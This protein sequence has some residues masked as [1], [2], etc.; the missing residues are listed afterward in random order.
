MKALLLIAHGSRRQASND[1]VVSLADAIAGEMND[2]YPIVQAGF[3]EIV[4]PS[5]TEA[6]DRCV[7][8]GACVRRCARGCGPGP[9]DPWRYYNYNYSPYWRIP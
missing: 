3:L 7:Q 5:I 6:I 9:A 4:Q 2:E 8:L 1:E